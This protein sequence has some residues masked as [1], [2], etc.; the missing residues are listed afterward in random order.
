MTKHLLIIAVLG[1]LLACF[2]PGK[3]GP[4]DEEKMDV[5]EGKI[6]GIMEIFP[7]RIT[8]ETKKEKAVIQLTTKTKVLLDGKP[9]DPGKLREGQEVRVLGKKADNMFWAK[10]I[11]VAKAR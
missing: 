4:P 7:L 6:T 1:S 9:I 8:V 10:E 11:H 5:L 3:A 2:S